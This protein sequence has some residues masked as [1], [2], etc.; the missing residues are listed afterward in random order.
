[1][2]VA[3]FDFCA[4]PKAT[5]YTD[6]AKTLS[7]VSVAYF[8]KVCKKRRTW[9]RSFRHRWGPSYWLCTRLQT[10]VVKR[11]EMLRR[12]ERS[13]ILTYCLESLEMSSLECIFPKYS[14]MFLMVLSCGVFLWDL[15]NTARHC[16]SLAVKGM[17]RPDSARLFALVLHL[18]C[19]SVYPCIICVMWLERGT[20][21]A[22]RVKRRRQMDDGQHG[23]HEN[24]LRS[25]RVGC[26]E[27][28]MVES[29]GKCINDQKW[30]LDVESADID[31]KA[32]WTHVTLK[33]FAEE[34]CDAWSAPGS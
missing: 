12:C 18:P 2:P 20:L 21:L 26:S 15:N 1:M 33:D 14:Q 10:N 29:D 23:R 16:L 32:T 22:S 19:I 25:L 11:F 13:N 24:W 31:S 7:A 8:R 4:L 9:K 6:T 5:F 28:C 34:V 17:A 27:C 30:P 3:I